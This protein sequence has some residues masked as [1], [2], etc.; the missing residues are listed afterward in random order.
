MSSKA[1]PGARRVPLLCL[2]IDTSDSPARAPGAPGALIAKMARAWADNRPLGP[3]GEEIESQRA[4]IS[5]RNRA[6]AKPSQWSKLFGVSSGGA[7]LRAPACEDAFKSMFGDGAYR[8][9]GVLPD[10]RRR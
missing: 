8:G 6:E 1:S 2:A 7:R 4:R 3:R 9:G 5:A 10:A